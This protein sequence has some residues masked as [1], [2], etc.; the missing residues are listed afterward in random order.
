M[1][2]AGLARSA[3]FYFEHGID[4]SRFPA[5]ALA[6]A[7]PNDVRKRI[8]ITPAGNEEDTHCDFVITSGGICPTHDDAP[9]PV[10]FRQ[11]LNSAHARTSPTPPALAAPFDQPLEH[12]QKTLRCSTS[13]RTPGWCLPSRG[14]GRVRA[15]ANLEGIPGVFPGIPKLFERILAGLATLLLL[16]PPSERLF[17]Q[18]IFTAC[19]A[20][21]VD[22]AVPPITELRAQTKAEGVRKGGLGS[23]IA[24]EVVEGLEGRF[25]S[26]EKARKEKA[27]PSSIALSSP[28]GIL[29]PTYRSNGRNTRPTASPGPPVGPSNLR[30]GLQR[31]APEVPL[32]DL[33]PSN[34]LE[35]PLAGLRPC[36]ARAHTHPVLARNYEQYPHA[37]PAVLLPYLAHIKTW[38]FSGDLNIRGNLGRHFLGSLRRYNKTK[39][40]VFD[41]CSRFV[42]TLDV[43]RLACGFPG[44]EELRLVDTPISM[45]R[46]LITTTNRMCS[47]LKRIAVRFYM[48]NHKVLLDAQC[49][50]SQLAPTGLG[51]GPAPGLGGL[52][53]INAA[54]LV[55]LT[56]GTQ[57]AL[58]GEVTFTDFSVL[59]HLTVRLELDDVSVLQSMLSLLQFSFA[60]KQLPRSLRS[61]DLLLRPSA[62]HWLSTEQVSRFAEM[63]STFSQLVRHH[64]SLRVNGITCVVEDAM[65]NH[66]DRWRALLEQVFPSLHE[67]GL[68]RIVFKYPLSHHNQSYGHAWPI[69]QLTFS[70]DGKWAASEAASPSLRQ[71]RLHNGIKYLGSVIIWD[72]GS[73]DPVMEHWYPIL[74][75]EHLMYAVGR[76]LTLSFAPSCTR[77]MHAPSGQLNIFKLPGLLHHNGRPEILARK[78]LGYGDTLKAIWSPDEAHVV[79]LAGNRG[80]VHIFESD[81][82]KHIRRLRLP[83]T[84]FLTVKDD[85]KVFGGTLSASPKGRHILVHILVWESDRQYKDFTVVWD[86]D[87]ETSRPHFVQL[88]GP[89]VLHDALHSVALRCTNPEDD[90]YSV[91][92]LTFSN[93]LLISGTADDAVSGDHCSQIF[94]GSP[95]IALSSDGTRA[96]L[97]DPDVSDSFAQPTL[98]VE[99]TAT[100]V[101]RRL[102]KT[103]HRTTWDM[104][105]SRDTAL[106][107]TAAFIP[108]HPQPHDERPTRLWLWPRHDERPT[109]HWWY[110]STRD[111]RTRRLRRL[112]THLSELVAFTDDGSVVGSAGCCGVVSFHR[113]EDVQLATDE[114]DTDDGPA[115]SH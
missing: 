96:L 48:V 83:E 43:A 97:E 54:T 111:G 65:K 104:Y 87:T 21:V 100:G 90:D 5:H 35:P 47:R 40:I 62:L 52:L 25:V 26:E 61:M 37:A 58:A 10:S 4:L 73:G 1:S 38:E 67:Q 63:S 106:S 77:L 18:Q 53:T 105:P 88:H 84:L 60:E 109:A 74:D 44:L 81:T 72:V 113:T 56:L 66:V 64:E 91:L 49:T 9:P 59:V 85:F 94:A 23:K 57:F 31:L 7:P 50:L 6:L 51:F 78:D 89:H 28:D 12:R 36:R 15:L 103:C 98:R 22:R 71:R 41:D 70:S 3:R 32:L 39:R 55:H 115:R 27:D 68:L 34:S 24:K 92:G 33:A 2:R 93:N 107:T 17:R 29:D 102:P 76:G 108:L 80:D 20:R 112:D 101:H 11:S 99:N 110:W 45:E 95:V 82:A 69:R 114:L 75:S 8:E 30:K 19:D 16:L 46:S 42:S 13:P 14:D 79:V 86:L